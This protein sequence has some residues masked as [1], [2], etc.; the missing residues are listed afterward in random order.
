MLI[1]EKRIVKIKVG[2]DKKEYESLEKTLNII[3][4]LIA[5]FE[6]NS[7]KGM[8]SIA[9]GEYISKMDLYRVKGIVD[10]LLTNTEWL[11]EGEYEY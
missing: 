1:E 4:C 7:A 8:G 5:D 10:G 2:Y 3:D 11:L 9:T 6:D